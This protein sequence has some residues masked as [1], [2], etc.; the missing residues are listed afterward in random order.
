MYFFAASENCTVLQDSLIAVFLSVSIFNSKFQILCT[1]L[2][3]SLM[4]AYTRLSVKL[5]DKFQ[6]SFQSYKHLVC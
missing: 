4:D 6:L 1:I 5:I 3:D 2:Q